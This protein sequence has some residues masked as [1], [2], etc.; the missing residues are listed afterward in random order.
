[1][2]LNSVEKCSLLECDAVVIWYRFADVSEE[3]TAPILKAQRVTQ[4]SKQQGQTVS[5]TGES[6][7]GY[8]AGQEPRVN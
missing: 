7:Y 2:R 4:A 8:S 5:R 1:M 6:L 3:I